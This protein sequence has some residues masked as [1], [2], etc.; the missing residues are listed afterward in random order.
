M[1]VIAYTRSPTT[2]GLALVKPGSSV[3][4]FRFLPA[5]TSHSTGAPWPSALPEAFGPRNDGHGRGSVTGDGVLSAAR[6]AGEA[7]EAG[8]AGA[9]AAA[10]VPGVTRVSTKLP[11]GPATAIRS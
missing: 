8:E 7:G 4:H 2:S 10:G 1:A 9:L 11:C 3:R 6:S 5:F